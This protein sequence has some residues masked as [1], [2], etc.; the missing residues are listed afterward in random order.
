[1]AANDEL[2]SLFLNKKIDYSSINS[3]LMKII[4]RKEYH[5][6]KKIL[7]RKITDVINVSNDVRMNIISEFK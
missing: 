7:P 3:I 6:L 5:K 2:V 4:K 1:M